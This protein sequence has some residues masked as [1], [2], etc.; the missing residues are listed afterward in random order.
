MKPLFV[1]IGREKVK[2]ESALTGLRRREDKHP[3]LGEDL[4]KNWGDAKC[5]FYLWVFLELE[6]IFGAGLVE[7]RMKI[8]PGI[9]CDCA[10]V[11]R[12]PLRRFKYW[13]VKRTR[14]FLTSVSMSISL[15]FVSSPHPY[16]LQ[17]A[18]FSGKRSKLKTVIIMISHASSLLSWANP[19]YISYSDFSSLLIFRL[20]STHRLNKSTIFSLLSL[21]IFFLVLT[22]IDLFPNFRGKDSKRYEPVGVGALQSGVSL[23]LLV[24]H[25]DRL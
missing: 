14:I 19:K 25:A 20:I 10:Y 4:K 1:G 16:P 15:F 3:S 18:F 24:P 9:G 13:Q 22:F 12:S 23:F 5:I 7:K 11:I 21:F 8:L 2:K 17:P 6:Q